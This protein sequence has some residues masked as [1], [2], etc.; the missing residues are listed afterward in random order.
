MNT[1]ESEVRKRVR[2]AKARDI[3]SSIAPDALGYIDLEAVE[4]ELIRRAIEE[5]E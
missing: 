2:A 1:D 5:E 3:R 4:A